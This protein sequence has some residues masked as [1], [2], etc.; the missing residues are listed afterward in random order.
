M[1]LVVVV[2]MVVLLTVAMVLGNGGAGVTVGGD[3]AGSNND[4]DQPTGLFSQPT[5]YTLVL[6]PQTIPLGPG[7][8]PGLRARSTATCSCAT[9][10]TCG[11][12]P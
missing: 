11:T 8:W 6:D 10:P 9:A 2:I 7:S 4:G 12:C 3:G 5:D 1:V